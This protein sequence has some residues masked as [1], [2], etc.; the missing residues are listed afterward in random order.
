MQASV[1][2]VVDEHGTERLV[3]GG[4]TVEI[5]SNDDCSSSVSTTLQVTGEDRILFRFR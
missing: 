3:A 2:S 4:Y 5:R 1:L